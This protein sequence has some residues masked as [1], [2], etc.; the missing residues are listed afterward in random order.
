M[1]QVIT[2]DSDDTLVFESDDIDQAFAVAYSFTLNN[3]KDLLIWNNSDCIL[4]ETICLMK[5][6]N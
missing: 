4:E 2:I 1:Y 3:G 5:V 6:E